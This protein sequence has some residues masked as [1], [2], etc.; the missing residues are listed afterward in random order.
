MHRLLVM[1]C[2]QRKTLEV[3]AVPAIDRY[4]GP[5]FRVLRK[6][7]R[8]VPDP[9]LTVLI[10]SAKHGLIEAD[11]QISYYDFRLTQ[12][13]ASAMRP[14]ILERA[15]HFLDSNNWKTIGLCAGREYQVAL[16]GLSSLVPDGVRFDLIQGGL[17]PRLTRLRN[18]LRR[19]TLEEGAIRNEKVEHHLDNPKNI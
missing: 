15:R 10:L 5:A 3:G 17:G 18:W 16:E 7:R 13:V 2:S 4:D 8:E 12:P 19:S 6:Y 11:H 1:S 9:S 14:R